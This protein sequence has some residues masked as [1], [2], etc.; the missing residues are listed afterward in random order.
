MQIYHEEATTRVSNRESLENEKKFTA[1]LE[2]LGGD[3]NPYR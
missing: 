3:K 2:G 1:D